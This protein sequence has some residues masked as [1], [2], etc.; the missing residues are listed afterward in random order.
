MNKKD[1]IQFELEI[2]KI[3]DSGKIRAP[4]HLSGNNEEQ[5]I[6]IF[7]N[8]KKKDWVFSTWRNHYHALLKGIPKKHLKKKILDGKSMG[9][10]NKKHNSSNGA[11]FTK[12]SKWKLI[13]KKKFISKIDALKYE[14]YLKKNIKL[15]LK[16]KNKAIQ[17]L[18]I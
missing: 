7:K 17:R 13:Y 14:Y 11:K 16:Y 12:G 5:L 6:K 15:R 4:V 10:M 8:I 9:I 2:K 18:C 3:Y 1:L